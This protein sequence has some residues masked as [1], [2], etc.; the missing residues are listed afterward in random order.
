[1]IQCDRFFSSLRKFVINAICIGSGLVLLYL[2]AAALLSTCDM[3]MENEVSENIVFQWDHIILNLS[4]LIVGLAL[5]FLLNRFSVK[6]D[7]TVS[8]GILLIWTVVLGTLWVISARSAPTFDSFRVTSAAQE[9]ADTGRIFSSDLIFYLSC[10]PFQLGYVLWSEIFIRLFRLNGNYLPLEII[11]VLCL[12]LAYFAIDRIV[13][14]I[15]KD[16]TVRILTHVLLAACLP[17]ILF[18]TFL[19]GNIPGLSFGV[20]AIWMTLQFLE[21][22]KWYYAA[23][24]AVFISVSVCLKLNNSILLVA[25]VSMVLVDAICK[26]DWRP[27]IY[28]LTAVL[29][30]TF[31]KTSV[32]A[33]YEKRS[34]V[35]FGDGIPMMCWMA[36]GLSEG[37]TTSGWY[38]GS[39]TITAF[40]NFDKDPVLTGENA[41]KVIRERLTHFREDPVDFINFFSKKALSQWNEPSYQSL[42]TNQVRAVYGERGIIASWACG[43]GEYAVKGYMNLYQQLI[44]FGAVLGAGFAMREKSFG[45]AVLLLTFFGGFLYHL[46]FEA[47]SQYAITY[48]IL[49]IPIA[50][51]GL[52]DFVKWISSLDYKSLLQIRKQ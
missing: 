31:M 5:I 20:L 48:F 44:L 29:L 33:L 12:A 13:A 36:M 42:W 24:G 39:Y 23:A 7:A 28:V 50:A 15:K 11:N 17:P 30:S 43:K 6:W 8:L 45:I 46:L 25:I 49:L 37:Y 18:C 2:S 35:D 3:N 22:K 10:Y 4:A 9:A 32:K 14:T 40:R 41:K 47:K 1:M 26:R 51:L 38:Q 52:A 34:G 27:L 16:N 19:Y 21:K